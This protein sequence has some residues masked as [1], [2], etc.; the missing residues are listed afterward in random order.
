MPDVLEILDRAAR[1][2]RLGGGPLDDLIGGY[3]RGD[4]PDYQ[5]AAWL[6]AARIHG[7]DFDDTFA[8][9]RAMLA[10]GETLSWPDGWRVGDKHSTG[11]VGDKTSFL[12]GPIC[13]AL[14]VRVPM[15]AGRGL[16]H[17]GGTLDKLEAVP[18]YRADL[19]LQ[20]MR[21]VM[22]ETGLCITGQTKEIAPADRKLYAL[23]DATA[24]VA[25]AGLIT[26]SILSKKLAE[27]LTGLVMDVKCGSGA[28]MRT[29]D[30]AEELASRL[31]G[32]G[33]RL[34]LPVT[35][36]ISSMDQPLGA[37]CGN[38]VEVAEAASLLRGARHAASEDLRSLSLELSAHLVLLTGAAW[39]LDEARAKCERALESGAALDVF[40]KTLRVQGGVE[41]ALDPGGPL[42]AAPY[43]HHLEA[44][45]SG[46]LERADA[47]AVGRACVRLGAG[48]SRKEDDVDPAVGVVLE[49][50]VGD[51]VEAGE[52]LCQVHYRDEASLDRALP[53]LREAFA[54][55]ES[56]AAQ[57]MLIQGVFSTLA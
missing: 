23:R 2:E 26:S 51:E 54:V 6:M 15:V 8:L 7:L 1:G 50:K 56:P 13:A 48:R 16:G 52:T 38:G 4:V 44:E 46:W 20:E 19:S 55:S 49:R 24:T 21:R 28:F 36:L 41:A 3:V 47:L 25:E 40:R 57:P 39:D 45:S 32:L 11:G 9:T 17:T 35:A 18:G 53:L 12:V 31:V 22:E 27:G 34:G 5:M 14:G 43:I 33:R 10:S 29:L 42:P 30:E 37:A